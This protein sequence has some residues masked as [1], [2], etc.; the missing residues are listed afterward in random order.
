M[1]GRGVKAG[2]LSF[3]EKSVCVQNTSPLCKPLSPVAAHESEQRATIPRGLRFFGHAFGPHFCRERN[4][5]NPSSP[6]RPHRGWK[7][8]ALV[9]AGTSQEICALPK[10][11]KW[12]CLASP[13]TRGAWGAVSACKRWTRQ[14]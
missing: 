9:F 6:M 4:E 11:T 7:C 10:G 1:V 12:S 14:F 8:Y 5:E 3:P 2:M 13:P